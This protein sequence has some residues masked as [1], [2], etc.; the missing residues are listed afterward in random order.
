MAVVNL[1]NIFNLRKKRTTYEK[2]IFFIIFCIIEYVTLTVL[3]II[4]LNGEVRPSGQ[5]LKNTI[6][7]II[8]PLNIGFT[9]FNYIIAKYR[10]LYKPFITILIP[11]LL[12]H[13]L[14]LKLL[15][16]AVILIPAYVATLDVEKYNARFNKA[17][18]K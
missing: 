14:L 10:G 4:L 16:P 8:I 6:D 12:L 11:S 5:T 9:A 13:N 15:F 7:Q 17:K 2:I 1:K 3:L 18:K